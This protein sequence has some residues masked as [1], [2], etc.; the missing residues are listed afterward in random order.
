VLRAGE[1]L[2]AED[3]P[4]TGWRNLGAGDAALFWILRDARRA[5]R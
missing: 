4:M 2:L 3:L 5:E 1:A